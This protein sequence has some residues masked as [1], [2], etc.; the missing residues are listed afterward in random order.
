MK[1]EL[2][3]SAGHRQ[4]GHK[5]IFKRKFIDDEPAHPCR[6]S[7]MGPYQASKCHKAIYK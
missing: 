7:L 1:E 6:S 5:D 2:A 3:A 4:K